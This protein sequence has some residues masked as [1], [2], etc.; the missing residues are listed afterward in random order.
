MSREVMVAEIPAN[1]G[2]DSARIVR[3]ADPDG[4]STEHRVVTTQRM[5]D[6]LHETRAITDTQYAAATI[7]RDAWERAG[8]SIGRLSARPLETSSHS[9]PQLVADTLAWGI[10]TE[11]MKALGQWRLPI[12]EIVIGDMTTKDFGHKFRCAGLASLTIALDCLVSYSERSGYLAFG[13]PKPMPKTD[14]RRRSGLISA[15][16][17]TPAERSARALK[18][19]IARWGKKADAPAA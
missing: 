3:E 2:H 19:A 15:A 4:R 6:R 8:L 7:L 14:G 12:R 11:A 9:V 5:I 13:K 1:A 16:R 10:Y 17:L 18:A